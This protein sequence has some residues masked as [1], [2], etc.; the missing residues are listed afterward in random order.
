M[1]SLLLLVT[2][3]NFL[4]RANCVESLCGHNCSSNESLLVNSSHCAPGLEPGGD[5]C[6]CVASEYRGLF[7]CDKE[8][9]YVIHGY[10]VGLCE[11]SVLCTGN[12][13]FGFCSYNKSTDYRLPGSVS[14]LD[15]YICGDTRT[16]VLC[17][18]CRHNY[19]VSYHSYTYTCTSNDNCKYGWLLYIISELLPLTVVFVIVI[20]FNISFTSGAINGF[21]LFA[22]LQDSLAV[23]GDGII[24]LPSKTFYFAIYE[25]IYRFFNFEFFSIE[26]LSFCLWKG[27]KVLDAMAFKY[28]TIVIGL[29][30]MFACVFIV[31]STRLKKLFSCLRLTTLK[32]SLIHGLSAFFVMCYS[33]CARVSFHILQPISLSSKGGDVETVV[34]RSGQLSLFETKHLIYAIPAVFFILTVLLLP[35]FVLIMHPL[36][37]KCLACCNLSESKFANGISRLVPIHL[38]DSFQSSFRDEVR[39]FAGV[40]FLYRLFPLV[41]LSVSR[42]LADFYVTLN[43]FF[44]SVLGIHAVVQPYAKRLHNVIDFLLFTNLAIINTLTL[45]HYHKI[46]RG[47]H[48]LTTFFP[49]LL[50]IYLPLVC[51]LLIGVVKLLK[52][53]IRFLKM[54]C[55]LRQSG[56]MLLTD[57]CTLPPLRDE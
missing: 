41:A 8:R 16:G 31:N 32:S 39:F 1:R 34:F 30:L 44:I 20:A 27:A 40:Y 23:H 22:Q 18:E 19:S 52:P 2:V 24:R 57:S 42:N 43:I 55:W 50:L 12:C 17:G 25:L 33:Q 13:P 53:V 11:H 54:K 47:K 48:F 46:V 5:P 7:K 26:E 14:E 15:G 36:L 38:L 4:G 29:A 6:L 49:Q 56:T 21:I 9:A 45:L 3:A 37:G 51:L 10:W 35:P 28:V